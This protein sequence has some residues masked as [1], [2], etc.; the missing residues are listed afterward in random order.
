MAVVIPAILLL[1]M[2]TGGEDLTAIH[3]DPLNGIF[4]LGAERTGFSSCLCL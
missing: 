2:L 3:K 4:E 1:N